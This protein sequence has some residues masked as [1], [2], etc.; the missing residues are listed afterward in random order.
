MS[1]ETVQTALP[2]KSGERYSEVVKRLKIK[3]VVAVK[4]DN[5][6]LDLSAVADKDGEFETVSAFSEEGI[7]ILRHSTAHLLANAVVD[8]NPNALPNAG[9][10]TDD[11]F[12]YDFDMSPV[13]AEDLAVIEKKMNE[14]AKKNVPIQRVELSKSDLLEKFSHNSYKIDKIKDNVEEGGSSSVYKQGEFVDFCLGP[15]VPSTGYMK[16]FKLLTVAST[17][18][19]GDESKPKMVRIYGTS[20]PNKEMLSEFLKNREEAAKRDHRRI[21]QE[22]DLLV[23]NS[24]RAP[25]FPLYT[26]N[27]TIL[28]N[29]LMK[30]MRELNNKY[31]WKEVSTPH[32]FRDII[33]KQ[34]GHYAKYKPNM[35]I[36]TLPDGDS[37]GVKP[38]NCPGHITIFER[39]PHSYRDLPI[40]YSEAGTVYRYEKSGEVGG[41]TRPRSFTIDDGHAFLR[42]DQI[43]EEMKKILT[44]VSETFTTILGSTELHFD[45]SLID[46][47]HPEN[48]LLTYV[49]ENC[50]NALEV[51]KSAMEEELLCPKCGSN[52]LNPDYSAW[53]E[54]TEQLRNALEASNLK[55]K[56]YPG[57]AA[58]YGPKIDVHVRDAIGRLWQLSTI[59]LDFFMPTNFNLYYISSESKHER[60]I[61]IHRAIYGSYERFMAILLENFAG[62]LPTWLSPLQAYVIPV[63]E[64]YVDYATSVRDQLASKG[65]RVELDTSPETISK[66]IKMIRPMRPSYIVVVGEKE[67]NEGTVT[68]RNRADKQMVLG[69]DS[70]AKDLSEEI[71]NRDINQFF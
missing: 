63:S 60:I 6:L 54:A 43:L 40:R 51:R 27:G 23:F 31:G 22:M 5:T 16:A 47:E 64:N 3:D 29:E 55:Y 20:F 9:P 8:V 58:F 45:L 21:G 38:M 46:K 12:Y 26:P 7:R 35:Y 14:I 67:R 68:A 61:M 69:I 2:I 18:Y 30:H 48:Y 28:R 44:M 57:E 49:C 33:W 11:G 34:S 50:G 42:Q 39:V 15:H 53:D 56:E 4:V 36:F 59:Q 62:K 10:P 52:K 13:S 1:E 66:K 19:K 70:F 17:H 71:E 25:G 65:I 24:E 41:L 37:Y 32:I